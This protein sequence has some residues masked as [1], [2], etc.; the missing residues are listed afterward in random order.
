MEGMKMDIGKSE[1]KKE[2]GIMKK[3]MGGKMTEKNKKDSISYL[4]DMMSEDSEGE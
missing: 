1:S 3:G 2:M 4:C